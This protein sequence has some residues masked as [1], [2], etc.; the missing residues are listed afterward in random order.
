MLMRVSVGIHGKD[1]KRAIETYNLMSERYF[2]HASPT[3]GVAS[4]NSIAC[5]TDQPH[6]L[7]SQLFNAGTPHPQLSSCFLV[8]MKEDSIEGIYDTLKTCA[9]ISKTGKRRALNISCF[10]PLMRHMQPVE[11]VST[12]TI[13]AP[14]ARTLLAPT[15][16]RMVLF[17]CS[18]RMTPPPATSTREATSV[19]VPLRECQSL[20]CFLDCSL[21]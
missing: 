8:A 11:S 19:R 17:P 18:A 13:S 16:T 9:M 10:H 21:T 5:P 12:S 15:V 14:R 7:F 2:T 20:A 3:V 6:P 4:T 1:F